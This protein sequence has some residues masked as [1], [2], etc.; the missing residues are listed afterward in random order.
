MTRAKLVILTS[1][2]AT[3][4]NLL[5]GQPRWLAKHFDV[6]LV[7]SPPEHPED[8]NRIATR[9]G[10]PILQVPLPRRIA[11]WTDARA[12]IRLVALLRR[13]APSI[14][15]TY[16]PKAGLVGMIAARAAGVPVR[17]HGIVGMPLM[18][19]RKL[20]K[21]VLQATERLTYAAATDLTC[22]SYGL[23]DWVHAHLT[24]RPIDVVGHGSINGIDTAHWA[25][26]GRLRR[27]TRGRLGL[28]PDDLA[29]LFV[30]RM[31]RDKGVVELVEAF[32]RWRGDRSD[33]HLVFVGAPEPDLDPLP[34]ET[35]DRLTGAGIQCVG[36]QPDVRPYLAAADVFVLPSYR[37]GLPNSLLEAGAMG[38]PAIA[39]NINGCNE[40]IVDGENGRL[41]PAKTVTPL[42][43]AL[44]QLESGD[45]RAAMATRSRERVVT[46]YD[47]GAFHRALLGYYKA[48]RE[49]AF[50]KPQAASPV[51]LADLVP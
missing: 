2:T 43:R 1:V 28:G 44:G 20:R 9:E 33:R 14:V 49:A 25:P 16:T 36:F 6:T 46:R 7:T 18:E 11:P 8:L 26:D 10:V 15:Q 23:R 27:E 51:D 19:A 24:A 35:Q 38:L 41:V 3:L 48:R 17:V 37:E 39:S 40:V 22:N 29:L 45:R 32:H 4:D 21:I 47:Q 50:T 5:E 13:L 34:P 42:V 30:G 31:V 12:L